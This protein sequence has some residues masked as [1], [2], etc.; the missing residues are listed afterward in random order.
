MMTEQTVKSGKQLK[1]EKRKAETN[2]KLDE[3]F[4]FYRDK[5]FKVFDELALDSN[6]QTEIRKIILT[7][8]G[9]FGLRQEVKRIIR[10]S[11]FDK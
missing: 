11:L 10:W 2:K 5:L 4:L 1:K 9:D 7:T 3:A 6:Q 8:F